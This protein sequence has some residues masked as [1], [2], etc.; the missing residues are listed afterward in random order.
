MRIYITI[1]IS[2]FFS[3]AF[4]QLTKEQSNQLKNEVLLK[5][6]A[7]RTEQKVGTLKLNATLE[8]AAIFHSDYMA[9]NQ[10]LRHEEK[11]PKNGTP[12]IRVINAGGNDFEFVGE[13]IYQSTSQTF[14]LSKDALSKLATEM[15]EAWRKSP[16]HYSN[17]ISKNYTLA[18]LGFAVDPK[19]NAVYATNV[20]G[21]KG[22]VI[23][24]Q[25]STNAF[26]LKKASSD[27]QKEYKS[28]SN[29]VY[30]LGNGLVI[31]GNTVILYVSDNE[32]I[33]KIITK[34][35]DG[36]A[37]D[38]IERGQYPCNSANRLDMS[39][40]YDGILLKPVYKKDLLSGDIA[41]SDY[42]FVAKLGEI[43]ASLKGKELDI[44][45]LI[46]K[47]GQVCMQINQ[48][49][50]DSDRYNLNLVEPTV[51]RP[52]QI[53]YLK[54]GIIKSEELK[55]NFNPKDS[56]P[57]TIPKLLVKGQKIH[58]V[59]I[60]SYSSID[61]DSLSNAYYHYMRGKWIE[62]YLKTNY[63]ITSSQLK[64]DYK[65]NWDLM[66]FQM[67]YYFAEDL[68]LLPH[69]SIRK[70]Y[71]YIDQIPW[72]KLFEAQRRSSATVNYFG[73]LPDGSSPIAYARMNLPTA[74]IN[75]DWELANLCLAEFYNSKEFPT[76][77]LTNPFFEII[78]NE[79]SLVQNIAAIYYQNGIKDLESETQ[80]LF[81]ALQHG[82]KLSMQAKENLALLY[83]KLSYDLLEIWDLPAQQL[84]NVIKPQDVLK[85]IQGIQFRPEVMANVHLTFIDYYGQINDSKNITASFDFIADY[86]ENKVMDLQD[87]IQLCLFFNRWSRY[88]LTISH[89]LPK[90]KE[91][92]LNEYGTFLLAKTM[93]FYPKG[94]QKDAQKVLLAAAKYKSAW[95]KWLDSEFSLLEDEEIKK[96]FCK[97]C[98]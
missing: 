47:N 10:L 83:A 18:D 21:K 61:G 42:R 77:I 51:Y 52:T 55:F 4:G 88:D 12:K 16:P 32:I 58:S 54:E 89:L 2:L 78:K 97:T 64:L 68:L 71:K 20:F 40:I 23:N 90:F 72:K 63:E 6:N 24:N 53:E 95:C 79:S 75:K 9:A 43:P 93:V 17:M 84:A 25:L 66:E 34:E 19:T 60:Q 76:I 37:V 39:S 85:V 46:I 35:N 22:V 3:V 69:D 27:C 81:A 31:E 1:L 11:N 41:Q 14:P 67:R 80:F 13:N 82:T 49:E 36:F 28:F 56:I 73:S 29:L 91:N 33:K 65:E 5:I 8:A 44:R 92:K 86:Y 48:G 87:E 96:Q 7:L 70:Y 45:L 62:R 15:F 38:V 57:I 26:G 59:Y 94:D 30:N 98:K 50:V 74:L